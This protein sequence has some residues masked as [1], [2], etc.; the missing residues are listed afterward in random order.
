MTRRW[1][2]LD[3]A[4][5]NRVVLNSRRRF[6]TKE[7]ATEIPL[8][9]LDPADAEELFARLANKPL[10]SLTPE[11]YQIVKSIC[12][13]MK[14]LP[15]ALKLAALKCGEGGE[16][17][18]TLWERLQVAP[19]TLIE[20]N[21]FF[22]TIH[23]NLRKSPT[24]LRLLVK[25][26]SFPT[27]EAP[28]AA[29]RS[30]LPN[31]EFFESKDK[32]IAFGVVEPAGADRL[33]LHPISGLSIQKSE[34]KDLKVEV[35]S[36][37]QWLQK[38]ALDHRNDYSSLDRERANLLGCCDQLQKENR[39]NELVA[40]IRSL[41][42]YLRVRGHWQEAIQ[43]LNSI[44]TSAAKLESDFLRGWTHLHRGVIFVLRSE[45]DKAEHDFA[46]ADV[47]FNSCGDTTSRGR[48]L[49]RLGALS[50]IEGNLSSALVQLQEALRL[51]GNEKHSHDRAG[52]HQR[53]AGIFRTQ[54]KLEEARTQYALAVKLG[55]REDEA[56]VSLALGALERVAG[57]Y[58][59]AR[60]HYARAA[61]L[62]KQLGHV[63]YQA[64]LE[65]H[66]G[67]F[68]YYRSEYQEAL[69]HFQA[70]QDLYQQLH[71]QPGLAQVRHAL[72]NIA[73][74][75]DNL[76]EA[77]ACYS[78][79]LELNEKRGLK[80]NA[81]YNKYQLGVIAHKKQDWR[82]AR[83]QYEAVREIAESIGDVALQAAVYLQLS[84]LA[85]A[86]GDQE[87]AR[88]HATEALRFGQQVDDE[89]TTAMALYNLGWQ[90]T[91]EG[92]ADDDAAAHE[93]L[94]ALRS[95]YAM[96]VKEPINQRGGGHSGHRILPG[97]PLMYKKRY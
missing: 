22:E 88:S 46:E 7:L 56:C 57:N 61:E 33:S 93:R 36:T 26:A 49:Y 4:G 65:Q 15:L 77:R 3:A 54:G 94:V 51:M 92:K 21:T 41:F 62:V 95:A 67:Y 59:A 63:L 2:A 20:D 80:G 34:A 50:A 90:S 75:D 44:L 83:E 24:A 55:D 52:A 38:F 69:G 14:H 72:G 85:L 16:S 91:V 84:S 89:L 48:V 68:N 18:E 71:Y 12:G 76:D 45:T 17:I 23:D 6:N 11:Q 97:K 5:S 9:P 29:L 39:W 74:A 70:A 43:R 47:F 87:V 31:E 1:L 8:T 53:L 73:E 58:D 81:V 30:G 96:N 78:Q 28:L 40:V 19:E 10:K 60:E 25:I 42:H 27:L 13:K 35:Q 64:S 37:I 82:E 66:L 86:Q 32:L 79:A